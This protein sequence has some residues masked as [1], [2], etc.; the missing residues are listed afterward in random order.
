VTSAWPTSQS[1]ATPPAGELSL[2]PC[3]W[4]WEAGSRAY[5]AEI[6]HDLFGELILR[7]TNAGAGKRHYQERTVACGPDDI[8]EAMRQLSSLRRR[9]AYTVLEVRPSA[10][11]RTRAQDIGDDSGSSMPQDG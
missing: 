9:H 11:H 2:A 5:V 8:R 4:R 6:T 3:L 10:D 7:C 1:Q